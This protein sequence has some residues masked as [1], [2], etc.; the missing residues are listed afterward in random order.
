MAI[1]KPGA[2]GGGGGGGEAAAAAAADSVPAGRLSAMARQQILALQEFLGDSSVS[3]SISAIAGESGLRTQAEAQL[4]E[5]TAEM[6]SEFFSGLK[7]NFSPAK[8]RSYSSYWNWVIQD[9]VSLFHELCK[10]SKEGAE[11]QA[12]ADAALKERVRHIVNRAT[13]QLLRLLDYLITQA[14][15][16]GAALAESVFAEAATQCHANVNVPAKMVYSTPIGA[17]SC[18]IT[19]AGQIVYKEVS[20]VGE[21]TVHDFVAKLRGMEKPF[22]SMPTPALSSTLYDAITAIASPVGLTLS[23]RTVLV[24]GCGPNS[25][26]MEMMQMLLAAGATVIATTSSFHKQRTEVYRRVYEQHAG[27]GAR[28]ILAPFNGGSARDVEALVNHIYNTLNMDLD[29][30]VPFAAVAENGRNI[31]TIDAKSE[32]AHRIMLTNVVRMLGH[33]KTHKE[34]RGITSRPATVLLPLSPN[35][36]MMGGDGLYAES[37]LGLESLLYKWRSEG[38][39]DY[40]SIIGAV[41]GWTRGTGASKQHKHAP[42]DTNTRSRSRPVLALH[43]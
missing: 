15:R 18:A 14:R 35:H 34:K 29:A 20:R 43:S 22:L 25:I 26:G 27:K 42:P 24:T 3:D 13:P 10:A 16:T 31:D 9:T 12:A 19:T 5:W 36:G 38:W 23:G 6:G 7:T 33:V 8:V 28:L 30:V 4:A 21:A 11:P 41:I 17:P 2:G 32:I 40:L 1:S 37:K 39:S